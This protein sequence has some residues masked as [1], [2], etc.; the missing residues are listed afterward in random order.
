MSFTSTDLATVEQAI[1]AIVSG[2]AVKQISFS[3]GY[4]IQYQDV[5]LDGLRKIKTEIMADIGR[6]KT[7]TYAKNAGRCR[8]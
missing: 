6:Y 4:M 5:T 8:S 3:N 7:R 2:Q 1:L